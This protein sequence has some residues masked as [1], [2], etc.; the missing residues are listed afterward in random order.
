[1][2]PKDFGILISDPSFINDDGTLARTA[3]IAR[4]SILNKKSSIFY[5][6]QENTIVIDFIFNSEIVGRFFKDSLAR[7]YMLKERFLIQNPR[8]SRF[9]TT[10][11]EKFNSTLSS[12]DP[13]I[14][15]WLIWNHL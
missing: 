1:V 10:N 4:T 9:Q 5:S 13:A 11:K 15:N 7:D 3:R 2:Y 12:L 8:D 14:G 6:F